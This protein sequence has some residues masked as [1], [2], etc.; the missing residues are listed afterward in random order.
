MK[1]RAAGEEGASLQVQDL[2]HKGAGWPDPLGQTATPGPC[3][4]PGA[5]QL[6]GRPGARDMGR[7]WEA[8]LQQGPGGPCCPTTRGL[9]DFPQVDRGL[10]AE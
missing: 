8:S 1:S 6:A 2:S 4:E 3:C 9:W 7:G 5:M 10:K